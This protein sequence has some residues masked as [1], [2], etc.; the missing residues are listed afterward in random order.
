MV[1]WWF[2]CFSDWPDTDHIMKDA[3][4]NLFHISFWFTWRMILYMGG[5]L[6]SVSTFVVQCLTHWGRLTHIC[7]G[8]LTIIGSDNGLSPARRQAIIWTNA[9][10][11]LIRPS[12]T[13]FSQIL[14]EIYV[15]SFKK[16]NLKMSSAKYR[17]FY[18]GLN[19]L[20]VLLHLLT[21]HWWRQEAP[22]NLG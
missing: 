19:V 7:V 1:I 11:L 9:G 14:I 22:R 15:F 3:L 10:I 13:Y 16:I 18:L 17:P 20:N 8:K 2:C 21:G 4:I 5:P 6:G 12:W